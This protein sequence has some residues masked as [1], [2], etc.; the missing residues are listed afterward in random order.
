MKLGIM[1]PYIFPYIG[2]F[3]LIH[4]VNKFIF[5]DDVN[6]IKQGWI[7][8]NR[9]LSNN[10]ELLFSVPLEQISSY[11]RINETKI[12]NSLYT[13]WQSKF[14][15]T[16]VQ[17]YKKA[18]YFSTAYPIIENTFSGKYDHIN[19]ICTKSIISVIN[20]LEID[21]ELVMTSTIYNNNHIA[22]QDRVIDIC[23]KEKS[24]TYINL[25]GGM[26][27]YN[28]PDF[29]AAGLNLYFIKSKPICYA[30]FGNDFIPRLSIID[31]MMFNSP[32]EI[33]RLI[34]NYEIV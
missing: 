31:V 26:E 34:D 19:Q 6:F 13:K 8:R 21:T 28:R 12:S 17:S 2:Y 33:S 24:T 5:Y 4:A 14:L 10:A 15:K 3:Q 9:I 25:S 7:N 22:G 1:Q 11:N 30:Q 29:K 18:P 23:I 20:Y 16:I 32:S 27:L